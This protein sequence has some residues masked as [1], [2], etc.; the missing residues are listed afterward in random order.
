MIIRL[1][2]SAAAALLFLATPGSPQTAAESLQRGIYTQQTAGDIDGAIQIYR[3]VIATAGVDRVT[4][5]R[6]QM[7]LVSAFLE[8][9]DFAGAA[10]EFNTLMLSYGDQK[11]VVSSMSAAMRLAASIGLGRPA[12][13]Q[14]VVLPASG[15]GVL[16]GI[17]GSS[18]TAQLTL[19]T[20]ENGVYHHTKTGTEISLPPN[21][22]I[23]EDGESSGGGEFVMVNDSSGGL[24]YFVW[25]KPD[26]MAAADIAAQLKQDEAYKVHQRIVDGAQGFKARPGTELEFAQGNGQ[27]LAVAFDSG[28][29]GTQIEY[30]V[31]A[32]TEKTLV[33]FKCVC[34]ANMIAMVQDRLQQLVKA[35]T[36]P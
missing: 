4:A 31:W 20:L 10:R 23:A 5:G 15:S 8:K 30:D 29:D 24:S 25:M 9:G 2:A 17:I 18:A 34:P 7:Q 14:V 32:R 36:I 16:G 21:M 33:Y 13:A 26:N 35:V 22:S 3:G 1:A 19:G 27:A 6:A 12:G 28:Q 11:E